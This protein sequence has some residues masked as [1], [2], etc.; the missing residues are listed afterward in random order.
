M[1]QDSFRCENAPKRGEIAVRFCDKRLCE[2]TMNIDLTHINNIA[3]EA[4]SLAEYN[5]GIHG[6]I[7]Y[8]V[9]INYFAKRANADGEIKEERLNLA[10]DMIRRM[11]VANLTGE[12][13]TRLGF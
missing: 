3:L 10:E 7:K 4:V 12:M 11:R 6:M 2:T 8:S 1:H 13:P 5:S 9:M